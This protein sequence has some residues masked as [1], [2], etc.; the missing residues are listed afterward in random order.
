MQ[1]QE[2]LVGQEKLAMFLRRLT[3][4]ATYNGCDQALDT[5]SIVKT[6]TTTRS[7]LEGTHDIIQSVLQSFIALYFLTK[8]VE[9]NDGV[10]S[11]EIEVGS[12]CK[13]WRAL[14]KK[15]SETKGAGSDEAKRELKG[16]EIYSNTTIREYIARVNVLL[17]K[18]QKYKVTTSQREVHRH[19]IGL[20]LHSRYDGEVRSF[21]RREK[22]ELSEMEVKVAWLGSS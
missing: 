5:S 16:L 20:G 21:D 14:V 22:F 1:S 9:R 8:A 4:W 18:L 6:E 13:A 3:I 7:I 12:P 19:A 17:S 15:A 11:M 10:L 2:E